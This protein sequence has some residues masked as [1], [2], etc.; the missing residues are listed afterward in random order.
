M[1]KLGS[2]LCHSM[3]ESRLAPAG[4]SRTRA[5]SRAATHSSLASRTARRL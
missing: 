2:Q 4:L 5:L 1:L 3:P